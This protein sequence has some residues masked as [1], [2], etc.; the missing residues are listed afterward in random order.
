M[1]LF[2]LLRRYSFLKMRIRDKRMYAVS[3]KAHFQNIWSYF[4]ERKAE[5]AKEKWAII[6]IEGKT[7]YCIINQC[8]STKAILRCV[9]FNAQNSLPAKLLRLKHS[10]LGEIYMF[11]WW[12]YRFFPHS[13]NIKKAEEDIE[14]WKKQEAAAKEESVSPGKEEQAVPKVWVKIFSSF[15]CAPKS[16]AY[17]AP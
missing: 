11:A 6:F 15:L 9:N 7:S 4:K 16:T 17:L 5:L 13:T 1:T 8:F 14:L 2:V 12:N 3:L 10:G